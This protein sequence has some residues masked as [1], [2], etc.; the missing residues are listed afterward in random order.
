MWGTRAYH[1]W[2]NLLSRCQNPNHPNY[3]DYGGRGITVCKRWRGPDGF[4]NFLA[5]MGEP[6]PGMSLDRIDKN[7]PYAPWNC[8]W[9][10]RAQQSANQ[11]PRKRKGRRAKLEDITRYA[12]ALT[13]AASGSARRAP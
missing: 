12:D 9:A 7:G 1:C 8:R 11:R 10:T 2:R 6:P 3:D 5:D 13:R 4:I